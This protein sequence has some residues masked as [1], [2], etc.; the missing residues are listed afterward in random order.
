MSRGPTQ[1]NRSWLTGDNL[2]AQGVL[3]EVWPPS[4]RSGIWWI[5]P[6]LGAVK[7][8]MPVALL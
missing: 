5:V 4:A 3:A 6:V 2:S 8:P 7:L 1:K